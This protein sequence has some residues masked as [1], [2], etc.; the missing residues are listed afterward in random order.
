MSIWKWLK[1][2]S[3]ETVQVEAADTWR[4]SWWSMDRTNDGNLGRSKPNAEVFSSKEDAEAFALR[5]KESAQLLND[6]RDEYDGAW[7]PNVSKNTYK[8]LA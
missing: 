3:G 6:T 8:G 4:V 2:P 5:L 1:L 7:G